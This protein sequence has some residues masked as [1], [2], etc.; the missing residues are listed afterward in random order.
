MRKFI[1]LALAAITLT[2]HANAASKFDGHVY[3][4]S[5]FMFG[6][7]HADSEFVNGQA[8]TNISASAVLNVSPKRIYFSGSKDGKLFSCSVVEGSALYNHALSVY[9]NLGNGSSLSVISKPQNIDDT[10][11]EDIACTDVYHQKNSAYLK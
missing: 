6:Q 2:N 9:L 3:L 4:S 7:M 8:P 1:F 11:G 10:L 5:T